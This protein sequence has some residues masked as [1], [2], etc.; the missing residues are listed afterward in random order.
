M[1]ITSRSR[2]ALLRWTAVLTGVGLAVALGSTPAQAVGPIIKA[3]PVGPTTVVSLT[4]DDA[5]ADQTTAVTTMN[6]LGLKGTFYVPTGW[7]GLPGYLTQADL[8]SMV[9]GGHEIGGHTVNHPD[10]ATLTPTE[11]IRQICQGRATLAEWSIP[12]RSFAYPFATVTPALETAVKG[13]G[14]NSARGLGDIEGKSLGLP[15][16]VGCG[17]SESFTPADPYATRAPDE[18]DSSWSLA[19]LQKSVTNAETTGGWLQLTF[20]HICAS[21]CDPTLTTTPT[22]FSD[23]A[24][25]LAARSATNNTT[26]KTVGDVI[27]GVVQPLAG[28]TVVPEAGPGVNGVQNP[29]F[30][31]AGTAGMPRC[32]QKGGFGTNTATFSTV[33]T[34]HTGL[35]AEQLVV[36]GLTS[37]DAKA[38]VTQDLGDCAPTVTPGKT[39]SLRAWYT[40]TVPTQF[41]VY[42]RNGVGV[43]AYW[44]SS[45]QFLAS[46]TFAQAV[47]TT[48]VIPPGTT[49]ISFGLNLITNGTLVSDDY[50]L[51]DA[52]TAPGI[53]VPA[54]PT[55]TGT[56]TVG[57]ILTA[58]PGAWTPTTTT[59]TYQWLRAGTDIVGATAATYTLV[60]ADL[61]KAISVRVTGSATGF[62]PL[63][64]VSAATAPI[65]NGT[66][67]A[68]QVSGPNRYSTAVAVSV[69]NFLP[70]VARVYVANGENFPDALSAAPAAAHFQS[71]VLLTPQAAVPAAVLT[72]IGRLKPGKIVV[73]GSTVVVSDAVVAQLAAIA[74][75]VRVA[76]AN[77]YATSQAIALDAFG[78]GGAKSAYLATGENYPDAV[79]AG[80]AA[81]HFGGPIILVPGAATT[82]DAATGS[83]LTTLGATTVRIAGA[84]TAVS[85][86]I[87]TAAKAV[88]GVTTVKRNAGSNRY[89]TAAA[90]NQDAFLTSDTAYVA[91][92]QNFPDALVGGAV[93]G[94]KDSPLYLSPTECFDKTALAEIQRLGATKVVLFGG[95]P[96]LGPNVLSMTSCP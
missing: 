63:P 83:L 18:V 1:N 81:A 33:T 59:F 84:P 19:D 47:A 22:I 6:Q 88:T 92:G 52:A 94:G 73:V 15:S 16:C 44:T 51:Y 55:I 58:V 26:V 12:T 54:T 28:T 27:G 80:P 23:F 21:G 34:A 79:A 64:V 61:G 77:R 13:C 57:Q 68:T 38:I 7:V 90:I 76:G 4:F 66:V 56:A 24:T 53:L 86:G 82:L 95:P 89:G 41:D 74:P 2:G 11:A 42:L 36:S 9:A 29:G 45:T 39:Y 93:A 40:S 85:T 72:E 10:L 91:T 5:N 32:W 3:A 48:A 37:G 62:T 69:A 70:G 78:A 65:A 87:E 50:A 14:F 43:W 96:A 30:E 67:T 46:A 17:F 49:G 31:D 20:H 75:V 8:A 60:A 35:A 71:P 25:W